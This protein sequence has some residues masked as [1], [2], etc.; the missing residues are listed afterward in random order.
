M[1]K[2]FGNLSPGRKAFMIEWT[3]RAESD[4]LVQA[5]HCNAAMEVD[6]KR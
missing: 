3:N 1:G 4:L 5:M 6:K 2:L